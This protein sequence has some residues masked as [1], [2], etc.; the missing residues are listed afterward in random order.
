MLFLTG[1][2]F[3]CALTFLEPGAVHGNNT[4]T[5]LFNENKEM[6]PQITWGMLS[7]R[8]RTEH[9]ELSVGH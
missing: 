7:G 5:G 9:L 8:W 2:L 4:G 1:L 3:S 6:I